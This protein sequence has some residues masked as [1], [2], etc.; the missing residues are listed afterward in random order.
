MRQ[1]LRES[2]NSSD[3][4]PARASISNERLINLEQIL[5]LIVQ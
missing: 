3:T 1:P 2:M 4:R 5:P